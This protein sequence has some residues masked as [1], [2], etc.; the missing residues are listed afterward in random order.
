MKK[1]RLET[2]TVTG[3]YI[4]LEDDTIP[5]SS[6]YHPTSGKLCIVCLIPIKAVEETEKS[7]EQKEEP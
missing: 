1:Y 2:I 6:M 4:F 7:K 3:D 5:L